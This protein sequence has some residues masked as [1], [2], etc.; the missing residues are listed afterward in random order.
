MGYI[1]TLA[2]N[3]FHTQNNKKSLPITLHFILW[4][5]NSSTLNTNT[6]WYPGRNPL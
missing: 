6:I 2:N 3:S 4:T 5:E 1:L